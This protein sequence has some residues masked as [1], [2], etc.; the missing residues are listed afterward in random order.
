[1]ELKGLDNVPTCNSNELESVTLSSPLPGVQW[2]SRMHPSLK[3]VAPKKTNCIQLK[4]RDLKFRSIT[5]LE[6]KGL[7]LNYSYIYEMFFAITTN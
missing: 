2:P 5:F 1:M 4:T 6:M 7:V 3:H